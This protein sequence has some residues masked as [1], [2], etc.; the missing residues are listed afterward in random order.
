MR[1]RPGLR[2]GPRWGSLQ[3]SPDPLAGLGEGKGIRR[4]GIGKGRNGKRMDG[5]EGRER[6]GGKGK[7]RDPNK[8]HEKLTPLKAGIGLTQQA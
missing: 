2:P 4:D 3:C 1:Q 5:G 7:G 6:R 8:F